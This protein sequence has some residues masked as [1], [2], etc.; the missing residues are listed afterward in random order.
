M[1]QGEQAILVLRFAATD[2]IDQH[3]F[4]VPDGCWSFQEL[5][6]AVFLIR[7]GKPHQVIK[8]N[9]AGVVV[10]VFETKF[11]G[12]GV[13][14]EGFPGPGPANEQ[15][16]ILRDECCEYCWFNLLKTKYVEPRQV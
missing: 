6:P 7:V 3:R 11:L 4:G 1:H 9:Q 14:Q 10:P 12:Q 15:Q 5:D 16:G 8:G 2:L 13:E